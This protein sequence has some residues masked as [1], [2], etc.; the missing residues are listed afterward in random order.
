MTTNK[1]P[2]NDSLHLG[3]VVRI[4]THVQPLIL[5]LVSPSVSFDFVDDLIPPPTIKTPVFVR[6]VAVSYMLFYLKERQ[7]IKYLKDT[8][9]DRMDLAYLRFML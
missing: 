8:L 4:T 9:K 3:F 7:Q 2:S 6:E 5:D 1:S